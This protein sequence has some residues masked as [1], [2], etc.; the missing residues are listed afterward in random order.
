MNTPERRRMEAT[1]IATRAVSINDA[2]PLSS[3][4]GFK[5]A[6]EVNDAAVLAWEALKIM[7]LIIRQVLKI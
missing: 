3:G 1:L 7:W 4:M 6:L 2:V 5:S